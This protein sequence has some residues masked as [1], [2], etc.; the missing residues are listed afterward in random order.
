[1]LHRWPHRDIG[2]DRTSLV[3]TLYRMYFEGLVAQD[4]L[5]EMKDYGFKD[6]WTLLGLR[7]KYLL[8]HPQPPAAPASTKRTCPTAPS[9]SV[10][11]V[12]RQP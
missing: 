6:S 3:A 12:I 4:A 11:E 9:Q 5:Q 2:R 1:M 8:K 7:K 10:G